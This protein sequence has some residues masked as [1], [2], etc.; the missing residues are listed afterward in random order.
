MAKVPSILIAVLF[1][2]F[3]LPPANAINFG[4]VAKN[5]YMEISYNQSAN[6][7]LLFWN[8]ENISYKVTLEVKDIPKDWNVIIQP[9]EF[10][11]NSTT[12]DQYIK[13]PYM[14]SDVRALSVNVFAKPNSNE[15]GRYYITII[16]IAGM[17]NVTGV[18]TSLERKFNLTVDVTGGINAVNQ[19]E[20]KNMLAN[21][22]NTANTIPE[23]NSYIPYIIIIIGIFL[24]SFI[25][26]KYA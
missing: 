10:L 24:I 6:F 21:E 14:E 16:T 8:T 1:L 4:S 26:Y 12:G 15:N 2:F 5:D 3:I 20:N 18:S 11:L 17:P 9:K 22:S 13:L 25:I 23:H 7:K 19:T